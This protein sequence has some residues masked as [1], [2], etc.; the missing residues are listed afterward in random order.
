M[1][2]HRLKCTQAHT[3]CYTYMYMYIHDA[4]T[5]ALYTEHDGS[6]DAVSVSE[7]GLRILVGTSSVSF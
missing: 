4:Y 3:H 6:V 2:I 1:Y 7:D 5:P